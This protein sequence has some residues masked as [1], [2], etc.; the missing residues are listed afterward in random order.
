MSIDLRAEVLAH[1]YKDLELVGTLTRTPE[2]TEFRYLDGVS[3]SLATGLPVS[4][5]LVRTGG[6]SVH[7]FFANLLPE[8]FRL[9]ALRNRLKT[10]LDDHLSM[11]LAV[12]HDVVGDVCVV[13]AGDQPWRSG[14]SVEA[15]V[16]QDSNFRALLEE[17]CLG[18]FSEPVFAGVQDKISGQ[19]I[20]FPVR[21]RSE[22][23]DY[24]LKLNPPDKPTLVHNEHFFLGMARACGLSVPDHR[25]LVDASGAQ[26]LLIQRF[27]RLYA[28]MSAE[29]IRLHLEDGCQLTNRYPAAK[30]SVQTRELASAILDHAAAPAIT[31]LR[32]LE[33]LAFS[34]VIANGD[35]HAKNFSLLWEPGTGAGLA[36]VYDMVSTLP[37]GDD[38]MALP[39]EGRDKN[40]KRR[41]LLALA[42]FMGI[43]D[44]AVHRCL[45][46][47]LLRAQPWVAR[48]P[49]AEFPARVTAHVQREMQKRIQDMG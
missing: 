8:G 9:T 2:G 21:G 24:I 29:P 26:G 23:R 6:G 20:S 44:K 7:P 18:Q 40:W 1:V 49:E 31:G 15:Q 3:S 13:N 27:D 38:S 19:M 48:V 37:Y 47:L 4:E 45:E 5:K 17:S 41:D 11:L 34:Y 42:K 16:A 35:M 46:K 14:P 28:K 36:P 33:L 39:L 12:G 30:Y 10:S 25:I 22:S 43:P 32:F